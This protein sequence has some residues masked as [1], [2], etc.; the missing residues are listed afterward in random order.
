M[1]IWMDWTF[2]PCGM[3]SL[4]QDGQIFFKATQGLKK[5]ET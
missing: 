2:S 4:Q 3:W 1:D 5:C